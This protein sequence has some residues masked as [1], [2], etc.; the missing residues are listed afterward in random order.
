LFERALA[1]ARSLDWGK[2]EAAIQKLPQYAAD[3]QAVD[4][5]L[6]LSRPDYHQLRELPVT[7][8]FEFSAGV[9]LSSTIKA[10]GEI[11][12]QRASDRLIDIATSLGN[13]AD[14]AVDALGNPRNHAA[15]DRMVREL[16]PRERTRFSKSERSRLRSL[17]GALIRIQTPASL[18]AAADLEFITGLAFLL[19]SW[20][21]QKS[22]GPLVSK[23]DADALALLSDI[24]AAPAGDKESPKNL[25]LALA[26]KEPVE[27][28]Q[29]IRA[30]LAD[31]DL[32]ALRLHMIE[33][34][35]R[36]RL[37]S[38]VLLR[39]L[40]NPAPEKARMQ[41][42][43]QMA[44]RA[45]SNPRAWVPWLN[46]VTRL[47]SPDPR[48]W[49]ELQRAVAAA[50]VAAFAAAAPSGL[51]ASD[52]NELAISFFK[53]YVDC[54][55]DL[56]SHHPGASLTREVIDEAQTPAPWQGG[57][58]E[59]DLSQ[60]LSLQ[61]SQDPVVRALADEFLTKARERDRKLKSQALEKKPVPLPD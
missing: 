45:Q 38:S 36:D 28:I 54:V 14:K 4:V 39:L 13:Y 50:C 6:E 35:G 25:I 56:I 7:P 46:G 9:H 37:V 61:A 34:A 15:V 55:A 16:I 40:P 43:A 27:R 17:K 52:Y 49:L 31:A 44:I 48:P 12:Q 58:V 22:A 10:L 47:M 19:E 11:G 60:I 59:D 2:A 24:L 8:T 51:M 5:L 1:E 23:K 20:D 33:F 41:L 26:A 29:A 53:V 57:L 32:S 18:A 42:V 30:R 3:P 21:S